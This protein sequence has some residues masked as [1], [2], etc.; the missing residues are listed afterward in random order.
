[1]AI[2]RCPECGG[3]VSSRAEACPHCGIDAAAAKAKAAQREV[4]KKRAAR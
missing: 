3:K 1:M 2:K 4:E